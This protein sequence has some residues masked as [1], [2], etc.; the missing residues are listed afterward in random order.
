MYAVASAVRIEDLLVGRETLAIGWHS[1]NWGDVPTW[2]GSVMTGAALLVAAFTYRRSVHDGA[3]EQAKAITVWVTG[4]SSTA[5]GQTVHVR[6]G[7][8]A[9]AYSVAI[10]YLEQGRFPPDYRSP[11]YL[12]G[13][14]GT[15]F[16]KLGTWASLGPGEEKTAHLERGLSD[17]AIPWLYFRDSDGVD[18]IRDYR[19][20]LTR[21]S[22]WLMRHMSES[23][24]FNNSKPRLWLKWALILGGLTFY[25]FRSW[26]YK[27]LHPASQ[28]AAGPGNDAIEQEDAAPAATADIPGDP[29]AIKDTSQT[30]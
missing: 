16:I 3:R 15:G 8:A 23:Y 29:D 25:G 28:V 6:N 19:A 20:R 1:L 13:S 10:Y 9:A 27:K 30:D 17:P 14:T 5:E 12:V 22:Y 2:V 24:Y 18:W 26:L 7:G 21:H 4:D 11:Y